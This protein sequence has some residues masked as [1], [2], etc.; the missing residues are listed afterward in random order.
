[1][2]SSIAF[3]STHWA[4][5]IAK[6]LIKADVRV[7]N[8]R[9]I[10]DDMAIV[11]VVNHFT[12]LETFLLPYELHKHL[13]REVWSLAASELFVGRIGAYLRSMGTV[14]TKDPDRD[15]TI[16]GTLL[17]GEHPW[18]IFPEGSMIKDKK[19][20]DHRREFSVH[21][22]EHGRR[23]P[24]R[25]A[26]VLALRAELY[27][28][29]LRQLV[30]E[31]R[32]EEVAELLQRFDLD[33]ED[34]PAQ[35]LAKRTVLVPVNVTYYP[36]RARE[37]VFLRIAR[38]MAKDLSPRA[39]EELSVEGTLLS[40]DTDIDITLADPIDIVEYL[41]AS[42]PG[43]RLLE[44]AHHID[45]L[46]ADARSPFREVSKRL[47]LRFMRDIYDRTTI[48]YDHLLATTIRYQRIQAFPERA[49][50]NRIFLAVH[51]IRE[52]GRYR[53]HPLL[54]K[55]YRDV[56]YEEASPEFNEF[57]S[58]CVDE[59]LLRRENGKY[60]KDF[61]LKQGITDFHTVRQ[62]ELT[63]VIANELEPLE[64][65][66][67]IIRHIARAPRRRL[68]KTIRSML[69]EE[70]LAVFENDY[71][72]HYSEALSKP[73]DVG[74]PFLLAPKFR[75]RGGIVLVHGY[76]AAPLEVRALAEYL[77]RK[78]Y[79]VYGVR[80]KGHGT[81]PE[82]LA[83]TRWEEW[84]ESVNRG[85]AIV[86]SLTD[87]IIL[88]G[89]SMGGVLALLAG[90]RKGE[91]VQ[92]IFSINAPLQLR[93]YA[94]KLVPS[95]VTMNTLF[96]RMRRR[97]LQWEY[98]VNHPENPHINY[99]RN[100]LTGVR[101]LGRVIEAMEDGLSRLTVPTLIVQGSRDPL[102]SPDSGQGLFDRI[103]S[104]H[105]ELAI[106]E[107]TRH[108]IINGPDAEDIFEHVHHFIERAREKHVPPSAVETKAS[109]TD[110]A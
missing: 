94:A 74:R 43:N 32:H 95:I 45:A 86:K 18:I 3:W 29:H 97:N 21:G 2:S 110:V 82:D 75:I 36:I 17:N 57:L 91:K 80:L 71:A 47:T 85:Y 52:L 98:V 13:G 61:S 35:V 16:V 59:G 104:A 4:L 101:E 84:Y 33:P 54:E 76:M 89:F 20:M 24:H 99:T 108:G 102:V 100:P 34:A 9:A 39:L 103:G 83:H 90:A 8:A 78:G 19:V 81:A 11:Y 41:R 49:Y 31:E 1:M 38:G 28:Q 63:Y 70:D 30:E 37:N 60:L 72:Q 22:G 40:E 48:N 58:L 15:K 62:K 105:K 65:V 26:A 12:R 109:A 23:P 51:R 56:L 25:G 64:D 5:D 93:S 77:Y 69:L 66:T 6:K 44:N 79:A 106:L 50:R 46:E 68:S 67:R 53:L 14:S 42:E 96:T 88:G 27:R 7:H 107:R 92:S 55:T 10:H 87:D 73:Q